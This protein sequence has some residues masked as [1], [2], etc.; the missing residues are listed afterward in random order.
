MKIISLGPFCITKYAIN[1]MKL[2]SPTMPFDWM[3]SS[4]P[5]IK[6]CIE[7]KFQTL[8]SR[9]Y[10]FQRGPCWSNEKSLHDIYNQQ[11]RNH[12][13]ITYHMTYKGDNTAEYDHFHMWNH[14][15]LCKNDSY[16][17]YKML[18]E[19][20]MEA[21][22][23]SEKKVFFYTLYYDK[24][25]IDEIIAFDQFLKQTIENYYLVIIHCTFLKPVII[26]TPDNIKIYSF[27]VNRWSDEIPDEILTSINN[28][29]NF[30]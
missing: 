3:F 23:S 13:I 21:L 30:K 24:I 19:R 25:D 12:P 20:F 8:L 5:F 9:Q 14:Y 26:E 1:K 2:D 22:K 11:I 4:L 15:N 6:N 18:V 10:I 7:D 16:D 27:Q 17:R 29:L 28:C